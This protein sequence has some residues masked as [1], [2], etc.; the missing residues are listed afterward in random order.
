[1]LAFAVSGF[2]AYTVF[3]VLPK[4]LTDHAG[5]SIELAAIALTTFSIMG[6]P[7]SLVIP[8]LAVRP[9]W[10]GRLIVFAGVSGAV[11]FLGLAFVPAL[12]PIVWTVLIALNTLTFSMSLALIGARTATHQMATELS[13]Y[14]NTVGY[15]IAA[16]GPVVV[17]AVHEI[18]DSWFVP[19]IVLAV[20]ATVLLP[21]AA[22][23]AK[24]RT[25]EDELRDAGF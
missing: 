15:L 11:G 3:A 17:G 4:I 8:N 23:L 9:G 14:V 2:T 16:I 5:A 19:L 10:S 20:F 1:M 25:I 13:G 21:A 12:A 22:V 7:M 6:M 18:T 24:E